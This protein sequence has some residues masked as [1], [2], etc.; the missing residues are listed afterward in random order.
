MLVICIYMSSWILNWLHN[1]LK[2]IINTF[3]TD[4][5][6]AIW[7]VNE[8]KFLIYHTHRYSVICPRV[9]RDYEPTSSPICASVLR[10]TTPAQ[11]QP[12]LLLQEEIQQKCKFAASSY[13][14]QSLKQKEKGKKSRKCK[15][16]FE[17]CVLGNKWEFC[18]LKF[19]KDKRWELEAKGNS[20]HHKANDLLC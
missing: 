5:Y 6:S 13:V 9:P 3:P 18:L 8:N 7:G 17:K 11:S 14:S 4:I 15:Q 1:I 19:R 2:E 10:F 16:K 12:T 20:I